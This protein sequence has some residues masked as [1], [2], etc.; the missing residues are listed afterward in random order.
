MRVAFC[1]QTR[2]WHPHLAAVPVREQRG[3]ELRDGGGFFFFF[4]VGGRNVCVWRGG[5][6]QSTICLMSENSHPVAR[7]V[8]CLSKQE[9]P[10]GGEQSAWKLQPR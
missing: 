4:L 7:L 2:V 3:E 9:R 5:G 8:V 1:L 10:V 6:A